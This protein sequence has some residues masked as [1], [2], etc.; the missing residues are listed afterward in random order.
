MRI[1]SYMN[2][3]M[4]IPV[5]VQS[6][7]DPMRKKLLMTA[8]GVNLKA[9]EDPD[10]MVSGPLDFQK[11]VA[12]SSK[13]Q[14][15][16]EI[17]P[18]FETMFS[19]AYPRCVIMMKRLDRLPPWFERSWQGHQ[20]PVIPY[21]QPVVTTITY[22]PVV[23]EESHE[24]VEEAAT[25]V[26]NRSTQTDYRESES[27][28]SPWAPPMFTHCASTPEVLTLANLSWGHG[29]PAGMHEVEI[30]ERARMKRAWE[31]VMPTAA[32]RKSIEKMRR[33]IDA[34]ER[35]E[36]LF[37]E[38]EIQMIQDIRLK[39]A[40]QFLQTTQNE[41]S[42]KLTNHLQRY[43]ISK[44][45][46]KNKKIEKIRFE[47]DREL[48]KLALRHKGISKKYREVNIVDQSI[49]HKSELFGPQI[50]FGEHPKRRHEVINV[51]SRFLTHIKGLEI[52]ET[53]PK[54]LSTSHQPIKVSKKKSY[55]LCIHETRWTEKVLEQLHQDLKDMHMKSFVDTNNM[56]LI[57]RIPKP[58][59]IPETPGTEGV[60]DS[61]EEQ[62]QAVIFLQKI[63]KGRAIQMLI[64]KGRQ[65]CQQ[66]IE[67]MKSTT[68]LQQ[69]DLQHIT[70]N[71]EYIQVL[72][73]NQVL[74]QREED[75]IKDVLEFLQGQTVSFKL[76]FLSKEL[77]R[78]QDE[79]RVHAFA[80]L[81]E[82]IRCRREAM[83]AGHRQ[84]E[85]RR[86]QE[87]D[88][89]FRQIVKVHQDTIDMY[90]E[91]LILESTDWAA[92]EGARNEVQNLAQRIDK[93]AEEFHLRQDDLETEELVADL[94]HNFVVPEVQKQIIRKQIKQRQAKFLKETHAS[95]YDHIESLPPVDHLVVQQIK[96]GAD[97]VQGHK[98]AVSPVEQDESVVSQQSIS[99]EEEKDKNEVE[100]DSHKEPTENE[101]LKESEKDDE[102]IFE[103][104]S[105][106]NIE[107]RVE[108]LGALSEDK[109]DS[110]STA[111]DETKIFYTE[112]DTKEPEFGLEVT[113][114]A[115]T[116]KFV[117][118]TTTDEHSD[119]EEGETKLKISLREIDSKDSSK[120]LRSKPKIGFEDIHEDD[121]DGD[122]SAP[123]SKTKHKIVFKEQD[124][125]I[126]EGKSSSKNK[127]RPKIG[128]T[129]PKNEDDKGSHN[130]AKPKMSF[131]N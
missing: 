29:L 124:D 56:G 107:E 7:M 54:L 130:S 35:E 12:E 50:R 77:W 106:Q 67:E 60:L 85:E 18:L 32:D 15:E 40:R 74:S 95:I 26:Q 113:E 94:I 58:I 46:E 65:K 84:K 96:A 6:S 117:S 1:I 34:M 108:K 120:K 39:L 45:E 76:D 30:I 49:D 75:C 13:T 71:R 25:R 52:L 43:W 22:E 109:H 79:R 112:D 116:E 9:S 8:M 111:E 41:Q 87:H 20:M 122:E 21:M 81:A 5:L 128:F 123:H 47:R 2:L 88:E 59:P 83:E 38:K 53:V 100:T 42:Q 4:K 118:A 48:R 89:M 110:G 11:C 129:D 119:S 103:T 70:Q 90:L 82:R 66:L 115:L 126:E 105:I 121:E 27:Q 23:K 68:A 73:R 51:R 28:T 14:A 127:L 86:H 78:L 24:H 97:K 33:I 104:E 80:L 3:K 69:Q 10:Y 92:K 91:D 98:E 99:D 93:A 57:L 55:E 131:R 44:Q 31:E 19:D 102:E 101:I 63:I 36:W 62:Y 37:R 72:Q 61:E 16:F 114:L 17:H 64:C 125:D